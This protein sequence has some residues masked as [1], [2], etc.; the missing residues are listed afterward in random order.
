MILT[1]Y[2]VSKG[3]RL[4][5]TGTSN[6][7][8]GVPSRGSAAKYVLIMCHIVTATSAKHYIALVSI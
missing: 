4:L 7:R 8:P 5:Q 6:T 1:C 3:G 2:T